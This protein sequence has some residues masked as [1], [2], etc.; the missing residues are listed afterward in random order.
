MSI[1]DTGKPP[2][3]CPEGTKMYFG[4]NG[5]KCLNDNFWNNF[6]YAI[7]ETNNQAWIIFALLILSI[8]LILAK[9]YMFKKNT[10]SWKRILAL[11]GALIIT[12]IIFFLFVLFGQIFGINLLAI[13]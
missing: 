10:P 7:S 12:L 5:S 9:K 8:W 6:L 11:A 13:Y 3:V 4:D 1:N 2:L